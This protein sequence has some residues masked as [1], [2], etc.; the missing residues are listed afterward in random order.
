VQGLQPGG[1]WL[2]HRHF[3]PP[4]GARQIDVVGPICQSAVAVLAAAVAD[5]AG[6]MVV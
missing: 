4:P 2:D 3:L 5:G 1:Q 6:P